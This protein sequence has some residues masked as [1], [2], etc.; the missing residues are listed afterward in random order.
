SKIVESRINEMD[1]DETE[2]LIF[3]VMDKE[4][5]AIVWLGAGLGFIMGFVNAII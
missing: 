1:V 5:K 2:R 3:S 4:L